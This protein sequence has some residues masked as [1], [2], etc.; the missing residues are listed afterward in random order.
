[1][2]PETVRAVLEKIA[3][4][5]PLAEAC[6]ITLEANPSSSETE[7]FKAFRT[8]GVNRLSLGVQSFNDE[9]LRFLGRAHDAGN[10]AAS[11]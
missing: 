10:G 7:K 3:S 9:T 11:D 5:W 6:E 1:M 2:R 4:L 8:A